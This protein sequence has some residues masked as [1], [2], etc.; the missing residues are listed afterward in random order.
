MPQFDFSTYSSQIFWFSIC[1]AILYYFTSKIILPRIKNILGDR[2]NVIDTDISFAKRLE[3]KIADLQLK[4]DSL[5]K[6][7]NQEYQSKIDEAVKV[8]AKRR[9]EMIAQLKEKIDQNT[10]KSKKEIAAFIANTKNKSDAAI[11]DLT[12]IIKQKI[13]GNS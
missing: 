13:F 3:D 1:F 5:R 10:E 9:E 7:A 11:K 6:S 2:R 12:Q 4:A 8:S